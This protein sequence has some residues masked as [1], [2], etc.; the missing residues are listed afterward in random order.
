MDLHTTLCQL[1]PTLRDT[2]QFRDKLST[3][4]QVLHS[5]TDPALT[6]IQVP[7]DVL[8][9]LDEGKVPSGGLNEEYRKLSDEQRSVNGKVKAIELLSSK[10]EA[11]LSQT[12]PELYN[13]YI[14]SL[15]SSLL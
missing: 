11:S 8:Q 3:F 12:F 5:P 14:K 6:Q 7:E 10:L 13:E 4:L 9:Q 15:D 2:T 1:E